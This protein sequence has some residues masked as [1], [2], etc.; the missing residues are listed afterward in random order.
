MS[1][2]LLTATLF[3]TTGFFIHS[4]AQTSVTEKQLKEFDI[5]SHSLLTLDAHITDS[6]RELIK[7]KLDN[8]RNKVS[9]TELQPLD[10]FRIYSKCIS[11]ANSTNTQI[12]PGKKVLQDYYKRQQSF[13]FDLVM[14]GGKLYVTNKSVAGSK[15]KKSKKVPEILPEGAE[16]I[17]IDGITIAGWM[18]SISGFVGSEKNNHAYV[19]VLSGAAFDFYRVLTL[20]AK[21]NYANIVYKHQ[22]LENTHQV[23]LTYP[24]MELIG[25]RLKELH[26]EFKSEKKL[27]AKFRVYEDVAYFEFPTFDKQD[28]TLYSQFLKKSFK[29][30]RNKKITKLIIDVRGN[31]GGM[32]QTELISY[33]LKRSEQ[34]GTVKS[35]GNIAR[36]DLKPVKKLDENFRK[37]KKERRSLKKALKRYPDYKGQIYNPGNTDTL[38]Y[39]RGEVVVLCDEGTLGSAA[40]LAANLQHF[41]SAK[42]AGSLP[43]S[44]AADN[45]GTSIEIRLKN[46]GN[47]MQTSP[48]TI[49]TNTEDFHDQK[50]VLDI[51]LEPKYD[52]KASVRKKNKTS[53][54]MELVGI[55]SPKQKK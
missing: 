35:A 44:S 8:A 22:G 46:S 33:F 49:T 31:N 5:F 24:P 6:T 52:P 45:G 10:L 37:Y 34:I 40:L 2:R 42:I 41:R 13:P 15:S 12:F 21:N 47:N 17:S 16:I 9:S 19:Y 50:Y 36:K 3:L 54:V 39:Y 14:Y 26:K 7:G 27:N 1:F 32:V 28:G 18:D 48:V 53:Q 11:Y 25:Q 55:L 23:R 38:L 4:Y 43:G 30:V 51:P 29:K 20:Q